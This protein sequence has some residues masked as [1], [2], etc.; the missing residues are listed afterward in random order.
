MAWPCRAESFEGRADGAARAWA[1]VAR[2]IARFEPVTVLANADAIAEASVHGG[3]GVSVLPMAYDD[4]WARDIAPTFLLDGAGNLAG[5]DWPYDGY[6]KRM[7]SWSQDDALAGLICERL[8][9]ERFRAPL[10]IEAGSI[11][12]DGAGTALALAPAILDPKRNPGLDRAAAEQ[13]LR[14]HLGV[15]VVIWLDQSLE[16]EP[17]IGHLEDLAMFVAPGRVLALVARGA[18]DPRRAALAANLETLKQATDAQGRTLE[19]VEIPAPKPRR[20]ADGRILAT[21]YVSL[22]LPN[23]GVLLPLFGDSADNGAFDLIE[24][25]FPDRA[26]VQV[27]A[28][29]I[30]YGG[31]GIHAITQQ[32]PAPPEAT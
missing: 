12:V 31:G 6:G 10:V 13:V 4:S 19:V 18:D 16:E 28:L 24:D 9:I 8:G 1:E 29:D 32:Q 15:D 3:K 17:A 25:V 2:A 30:V 27:D 23:G 26:V 20:R 5:I 22:Y 7:P 14:D 11:H 21:S